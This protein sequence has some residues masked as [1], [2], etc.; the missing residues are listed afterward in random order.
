MFSAKVEL[1]GIDFW[2]GEIIATQPSLCG[3]NVPFRHGDIKRIMLPIRKHKSNFLPRHI[4]QRR[5]GRLAGRMPASWRGDCHA[6]GVRLPARILECNHESQ[7]RSK[8]WGCF[9]V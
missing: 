7:S 5:R 6:T 9:D 8:E 1:C 3:F 4:L 2:H